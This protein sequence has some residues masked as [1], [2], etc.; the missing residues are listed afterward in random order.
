MEKVSGKLTI[1]IFEMKHPNRDG[2]CIILVDNLQKLKTKQRSKGTIN[3]ELSLKVENASEVE[4]AYFDKHDTLLSLLFF[5][6]GPISKAS[7]YLKGVNDEFEMES[8]G[9]IHLLIQFGTFFRTSLS[10]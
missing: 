1:K 10:S 7:E 6:L 8:T 2:Y 3:E 9:T 4:I 5:K